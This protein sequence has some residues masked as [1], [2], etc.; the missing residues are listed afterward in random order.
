PGFDDHRGMLHGH[1]IAYPPLHREGDGSR[2]L[3]PRKLAVRV[4]GKQDGALR[5][6]APGMLQG[7]SHER[8]EGRM[9]L[10]IVKRLARNR[11]KV[12]FITSAGESKGKHACVA[13]RSEGRV[14]PLLPLDRRA[15]R[16]DRR[17][18][19]ACVELRASQ[20]ADRPVLTNR[21]TASPKELLLAS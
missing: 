17:I 5:L 9:T 4:A 10:Q 12:D 21:E 15:Q 11:K 20:V 8:R 3:L 18:E 2:W 14:E 1:A 19:V 16:F 6:A 13:F 7:G